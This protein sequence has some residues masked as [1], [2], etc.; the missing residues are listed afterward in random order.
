MS[1]NAFAYGD[2]TCL[3]ETNFIFYTEAWM[4]HQSYER[5]STV[6]DVAAGTTVGGRG[7][8]LL[9]A[10]WA[11]LLSVVVGATLSMPVLAQDGSPRIG[12]AVA[13]GSGV[14]VELHQYHI[15]HTDDGKDK[16][17]PL[18]AIKPGD[19]VE[20]EATYTNKSAR[21]VTGLVAS[22]PVPVEVE[23]IAHSAKPSGAVFANHDI[24]KNDSYQAEPLMRLRPGTDGRMILAPVPLAEYRAIHWN[25][26]MIESGKQVVVSARMRLAPLLAAST[27][28]PLQGED[29]TGVPK[30]LIGAPPPAL[31][32]K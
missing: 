1:K 31:N 13:K 2:I 32:Q 11:L 17:E 29:V 20:Y 7:W 6:V 8:R 10:G 30:G 26:G 14:V 18:G 25:V 28:R 4:A 12:V 3:R 23:Y 27:T 21:V 9:F 22:L 24:Q 15:V 5:N 19:V 16:R